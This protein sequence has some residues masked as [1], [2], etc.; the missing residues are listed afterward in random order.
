M[1]GQ[2]KDGRAIEESLRYTLQAY[3]YMKYLNQIYDSRTN[4]ILLA[5]SIVLA[6]VVGL[7]SNLH[8][9][10][11]K[12][13]W[14][15][16]AG[17]LAAT[18]MLVLNLLVCMVAVLP[19]APDLESPFHSSGVVPRRLRRRKYPEA[20]EKYHADIRGMTLEKCL[21]HIARENFALASVVEDKDRRIRWAFRSLVVGLFFVV[22]TAAIMIGYLMNPQSYGPA[23]DAHAAAA[24]KVVHVPHPQPKP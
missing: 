17:L 24:Q 7:V 9:D 4:Y 2:D 15:V 18:L 22:V 23:P 13:P 16:T 12:V 3:D 6:S 1:T 11:S 21:E 19:K 8:P 14:P 10:L 5:N 20:L